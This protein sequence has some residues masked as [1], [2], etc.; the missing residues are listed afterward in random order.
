[1]VQKLV[2]L[3]QYSASAIKRLRNGKRGENS[4]VNCV[5]DL[6]DW[7]LE[8]NTCFATIFNAINCA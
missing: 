8:E 3:V 2:T 6:H 7:T 1:M 4:P 5:L